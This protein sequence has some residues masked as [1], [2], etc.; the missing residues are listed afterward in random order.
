MLLD[1]FRLDGKVA[2]VT[3]AGKGIGAGIAAGLAEVG[4]TVACL[5]R[6]ESDLDDVVGRIEADGGQAVAVPCDVTDSAQMASATA[7]VLDT[8]GSI[9]VLVNNAGAAGPGF[10][11]VEQVDMAAFEKTLRINL[12]SAYAMIHHCAKALRR[13]GGAV[14]NISSAMS[15]LADPYFA[16]YAAA[17]AGMNQMTRVL[18]QELAPSVRVNCIV[19]GAVETPG[20]AA[21]LRDPEARAT[22]AFW[23][24]AG[25]IGQP[26]DIASATLYFASAASSFVSGKTLEVDGGLGP[27]SGGT[28]ETR[29]AQKKPAPAG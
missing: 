18:A 4:A 25:R 5:A 21:M 6:T 27:L 12:S 11:P 2:I 16:A 24:P 22:V 28:I 14:V 1:L 29:V 9:D 23:I 13:D 10:G 3:G 7:H 26:R 20:S 19:P 15:W 8:L 17:K